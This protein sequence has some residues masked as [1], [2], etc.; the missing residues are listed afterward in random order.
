MEK[1]SNYL[2]SC[3][4]NFCYN[5]KYSDK[6][7]L[8]I[9]LLFFVLKVTAYVTEFE[10]IMNLFCFYDFTDRFINT[11]I[12]EGWVCALCGYSALQFQERQS[13]G[14]CILSW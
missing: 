2:N 12:I 10:S 11:L 6:K 1:T 13:V 3:L 8:Q 5:N 4:E 7:L 14:C 9:Q